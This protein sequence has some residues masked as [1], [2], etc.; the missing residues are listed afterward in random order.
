[1]PD[2]EI[3]LPKPIEASRPAAGAIRGGISATLAA[4]AAIVA[5]NYALKKTHDPKQAE[6][7]SA[8]AAGLVGGALQYAGKWIRK[9]GAKYGKKIHTPV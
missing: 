3:L 1:M 7:A 6:I 2:R 4:M 8:M 5:Y 9:I